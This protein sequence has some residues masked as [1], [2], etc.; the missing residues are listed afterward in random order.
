MG[1]QTVATPRTLF[2]INY[3]G[4]LGDADAPGKRGIKSA[5]SR[6][7]R[8]IAYAHGSYHKPEQRMG[9]KRSP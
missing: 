5:F 8:L 6:R 1:R 7:L 3:L 9:I 2:R 4:T